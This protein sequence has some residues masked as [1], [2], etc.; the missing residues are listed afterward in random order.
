MQTLREQPYTVKDIDTIES[1]QRRYTKR[2]PGLKFYHTL[3]VCSVYTWSG[4][5]FALMVV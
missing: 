2:V 3:S 1:V 5:N 4:L